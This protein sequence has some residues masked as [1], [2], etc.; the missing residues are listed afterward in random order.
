MLEELDHRIR[1]V[2]Q[3]PDGYIYMTTDEKN[4]VVLRLEP[5]NPPAATASR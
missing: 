4:G 1:D 2:K 3:G 5:A